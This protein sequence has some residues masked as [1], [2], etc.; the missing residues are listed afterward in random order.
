MSFFNAS[1]KQEDVKQG[2]SAYITQS[3]VYPVTILAPV[4]DVSDKGSTTVNP[5]VKHQGQDQIVYGNLR[6]TNN[7]GSEN[8]IGSKIFNQ[9][10]IIAGLDSVAEPIEAELPIGP[11]GKMKTVDV[12]E[13]LA[14][15]DV[16][17]RIQMEY[18]VYNGD[19]K[20]KKNIKAF[21]RASDNATAEEIV[22]GDTPGAGFEREQKYVHMVTYK[23]GLD[24]ETVQQWIKDKR[25]KNSVGGGEKKKPPSFGSKRFGEKSE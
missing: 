10:L 6:I 4:V 23:D 20:E 17:M 19:I 24:E 16:L 13:D 2:G 22:N 25:P 11:K 14:D 18:N 9:L 1:K 3:G 15:L 5:F 12:L 8:K 21:F 7:D